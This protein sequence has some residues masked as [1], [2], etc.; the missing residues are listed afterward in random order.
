MAATNH[1]RARTSRGAAHGTSTDKRRPTDGRS[2]DTDPPAGAAHRSLAYGMSREGSATTRP[3]RTRR[4]SPERAPPQVAA[5]PQVTQV[6]AARQ[7]PA[8]LRDIRAR[9]LVAY[10]TCVTAQQALLA[11]NGEHDQEIA[12]CLRWGVADVLSAQIDVLWTASSSL[13]AAH[14]SL[15]DGTTASSSPAVRTSTDDDFDGG[16]GDT[17]V[18][19]AP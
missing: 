19:E 5:P 1:T 15:A 13:S 10:A 14:G 4:P 16:C 18:P 3:S 17:P 2:P 9:L 7:A 6:R 8:V 12:R 11:Q